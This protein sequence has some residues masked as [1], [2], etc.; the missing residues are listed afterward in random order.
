MTFDDALVANESAAQVMGN[1]TLRVIAAELITFV[2]LGKPDL[3][4]QGLHSGF[5]APSPLI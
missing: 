2:A 4:P 3:I 1:A 5:L